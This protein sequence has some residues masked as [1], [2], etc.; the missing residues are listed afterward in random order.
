MRRVLPMLL[1]GMFVTPATVRAQVE[2][3]QPDTL[4]RLL[5]ISSWKCPQSAVGPISEAYDS[6]T[7]PIEEELV[8]AG[9]YIGGGMYFHQWADEW[10]VN[11]YRLAMDMD[12]L[13][14]AT[15]EIANLTEER[16]PD[17]PS[18]FEACTE[19]KDGIYFWGPRTAPPPPSN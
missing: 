2:M 3:E 13:F 18:M 19:H 8:A 6:I 10:N 5:A 1:L 11:Y 9:R 16:H 14:A 7:R 4:P 17:A 15:E 12:Q